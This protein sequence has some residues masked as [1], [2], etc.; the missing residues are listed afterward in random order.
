M[1]NKR[2]PCVRYSDWLNAQL[3]MLWCYDHEVATGT[4][5][6]QVPVSLGCHSAWLIRSGFAQVERDHHVYRAE[7]GD[8][9]IVP[10]GT[11]IRTFGGQTHML[12]IGFK[13]Q[14]PDGQPLLD[15]GLPVL[16]HSS[17]HPVLVERAERLSR[18]TAMPS[19]AWDTRKQ[20]LDCRTFLRISAEAHEWFIELFDVLASHGVYP[21]MRENIDP[22]IN[23]AIQILNDYPLDLPF[24][25]NELAGKVGLSVV[26]LVRLFRKRL[27]MTPRQYLDDRR[28]DHAMAALR[29]SDARPKAVA[30]ALGFSYLSHFSSWFKKRTG[31]TPRM[32]RQEIE[33]R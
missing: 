17:S 27:K 28:L 26:H 15:E 19:S 12:S 18:L 1:K 33:S 11:F 21:N 9:L 23:R 24:D 16:F 6:H 29:L 14:W 4:S 20:P 2:E 31:I 7:A 25:K 8:W 22:R 13:T 30:Y 5:R 32:F 3:H 10:K